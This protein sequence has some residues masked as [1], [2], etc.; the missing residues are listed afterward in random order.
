MNCAHLVTSDSF[1]PRIDVTEVSED[2]TCLSHGQAKYTPAVNATYSKT[3]ETNLEKWYFDVGTLNIPKT[4]PSQINETGHFK[5]RARAF[6]ESYPQVLTKSEI[7]C[8]HYAFII[9]IFYL[10]DASF[11]DSTYSTY[12]S[13]TGRL[14]AVV[15]FSNGSSW[16]GNFDIPLH[17]GSRASAFLQWVSCYLLVLS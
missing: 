14:E 3:S 11:W 6:Y 16:T 9:I 15:G 4:C 8:M 17:G 7:L 12:T 2:L 1:V 5:F 13:M 10:Q